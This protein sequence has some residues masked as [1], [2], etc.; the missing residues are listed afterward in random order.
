MSTQIG[1]ETVAKIEA[2]WPKLLDGIAAGLPI[3]KWTRHCGLVPDHVRAYRRDRPERDAEYQRA[4][5]QSADSF[6]DEILSIIRKKG[7]NPN[8][9]RVRVDALK[10]AAGKRHPKEYGDRAQLDLTVK[11]LD[12]TQ[13]TRDA[14]TRLAAARAARII[15]G[16]AQRVEEGSSLIQELAD[17]R[18]V[19][20]DEISCQGGEAPPYPQTGGENSCGGGQ[21]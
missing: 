10:W 2:V 13:I 5:E 9:A 19:E 4:R 16:T 14:Q 8:H 7:V 15:D 1:P 12:L 20:P 17:L 3:M 21:S 6:I 11:T 18:G